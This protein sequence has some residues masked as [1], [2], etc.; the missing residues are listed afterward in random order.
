MGEFLRIWSDL[1]VMSK[2]LPIGILQ[3]YFHTHDPNIGKSLKETIHHF[4][5][6]D[7]EAIDYRSAYHQFSDWLYGWSVSDG[8]DQQS[9]S[10]IRLPREIVMT[11]D[12]EI[13]D[14]QRLMKT[15]ET[16]TSLS[17]RNL[18]VLYG[19]IEQEMPRLGQGIDT[20][21]GGVKEHY[22]DES[23]Y[24]E[25]ELKDVW[26]ERP[27]EKHVD[28][29]K[30]Q[31]QH[32][33]S[34]GEQGSE[35]MNTDVNELFEQAIDAQVNPFQHGSFQFLAKAPSLQ[36]IEMERENSEKSDIAETGANIEGIES[37]SESINSLRRDID[38]VYREIDQ[39][40]EYTLLT[41]SS[42]AAVLSFAELLEDKQ[43][44]TS[45][46]VQA[47]ELSQGFVSN[48][49]KTV[50]DLLHRELPN[51]TTLATLR[52]LPDLKVLLQ[53]M[54]ALRAT[55]GCIPKLKVRKL[56]YKLNVINDLFVLV[57]I[58]LFPN[59]AHVHK[60]G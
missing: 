39:C 11:T 41:I 54:I 33:M 36:K 45:S 43:L 25:R 3:H 56:H 38:H 14:S 47:H 8:I 18:K 20:F 31:S 28:E 12:R 59:F 24:N 26:G 60:E 19:D 50:W 9:I 48:T 58:H 52:N 53:K 35:L 49:L 2:I 55:D 40:V 7:L 42:I 46:L 27:I 15:F 29:V 10:N 16:L 44:F 21:K 34:L 5:M 6:R 4:Q 17:L 57:D 30:Y 13:Q 32:K 37:G 1:Q 51:E 22:Q 23:L